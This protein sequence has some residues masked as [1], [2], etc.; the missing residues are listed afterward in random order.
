L[1]SG[2]NL[3]YIT[4]NDNGYIVSQQIRKRKKEMIEKVLDEDGYIYNESKT[5]KIKDWTEEKQVKDQTGNPH[6]LKEKVVSFW[7]KD[8]ET[9]EKYKRGNLEEIIEKFQKNPKLYTASNAYGVKKYLKEKHVDQET[10]EIK[11][12]NPILL[13]D[14]EKYNRDCALDGYYMIVTSELNLS[15]EEI[16]EKYS[17][18]SRIEE[19]FRI[20]KSDLEGRPVYVWTKEH[21]EAHFLICFMALVIMRILQKKLDYNYSAQKIQKALSGATCKLITQEIYSL[22]IQDDTYQDIERVNNVSLNKAY[23]KKTELKAYQRNVNKK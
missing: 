1:N 20:I 12:K 7:S 6:I 3:L 22:E 11:K 19:S 10:G 21:I 8:F 16:I 15:N 2:N 23:V 18:L 17:G 14:Q 5:F 13:F 4:N 9:R